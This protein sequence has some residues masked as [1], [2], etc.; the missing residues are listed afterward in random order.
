M[1]TIKIKSF[2]LD[3]TN[4]IEATWVDEV[5]STNEETKEETITETQVHCES[6][7]GHPEHIAM[8]RAKALEFGTSLDEFEDLITQAE[9]A[10]TPPTQEELDK[11]LVIQ[12][13]QEYKAYLLATDFKMTVDYYAT[14]TSAEQLELTA[15]R[16]EAR[17]YIRVNEG[18]L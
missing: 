7:S 6:Y 15:K 16:Q 11:A 1:S 2:T 8:L 4:W 5:V 12:K 18:V 9:Q 13:V 14:L 10:Y 17:E 3:E